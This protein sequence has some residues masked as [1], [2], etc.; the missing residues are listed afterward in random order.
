MNEPN[1]VILAGGA[2]SRMKRG[3][4][5]VAAV[6]PALLSDAKTIAKSMLRV[7]P[8]GRPFL[9]YL[10]MSVEQAGYRDVMIVVGATDSSIASY[11]R[12]GG[13]SA[14]FPGLT[15]GYVVQP[16]PEGRSKPLGT[17][18][19]VLRALDA[20]PDWKRRSFTVCNSDN[21]YS[22]K[23]LRLLM[24][25]DVPNALIDYDRSALQFSTDRI[26]QFAVIRK[27]PE[28]FCS[29]I[30]EKP[31]AENIRQASEHGGRVGVSMNIFRLSYDHVYPFLLSI[32]LHPV[33]NEKELPVVVKTMAAAHPRSVQAIPLAEH[34]IDLT[35]PNDIP[36]VI[37]Y[38]RREFPDCRLSE[39]RS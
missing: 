30:I 12:D 8:A 21:L 31:S 4:A 38:L 14:Q 29:D 25:S 37:E 26:G 13:H 28:G 9:D 19:A 33:R 6:D 35:S 1:I 7:G 20:R 24:D 36:L 2:S 34:V 11:Y 23:A 16:I 39:E 18:D 15:I 32:P 17:A 27:D 22:V 5:N 10:L 3:H